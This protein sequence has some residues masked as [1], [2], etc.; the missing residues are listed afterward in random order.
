MPSNALFADL[1]Q[2]TMLRA[3][4]ELGMASPSAF[5]L[6]VRKLPA[7]R[8]FLIACGLAELLRE[9]KS[10]RFCDEQ[11]SYLRRLGEF[12][13]RSWDGFEGFASPATF[14]RCARERPF[15]P[16]SRSSKSW[17]RLQKRSSSR[18]SF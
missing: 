6:F 16:M 4:F 7:R 13:I 9:I 12:R 14:M 5:S 15:S 1:Y 3:Y 8:N 10:L 11:L 2:L 18:R 17:R